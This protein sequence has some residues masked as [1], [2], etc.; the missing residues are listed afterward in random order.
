[1]KKQLAMACYSLGCVTGQLV[2]FVQGIRQAG[3]HFREFEKLIN[4]IK[5]ARK[6]GIK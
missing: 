6:L 5:K 4:E 3:K 1:M 2:L